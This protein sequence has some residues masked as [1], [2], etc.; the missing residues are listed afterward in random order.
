MIALVFGLIL[1]LSSIVCAL[2]LKK[3]LLWLGVPAAFILMLAGC[4]TS[5]PTGYTGIVTTFGRV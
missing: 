4:Y 5:V 2:L 1:M 3:K